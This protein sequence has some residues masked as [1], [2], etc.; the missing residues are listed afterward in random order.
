V[1]TITLSHGLV[2]VKHDKSAT[3]VRG[4]AMTAGTAVTHVEDA[5]AGGTTHADGVRRLSGFGYGFGGA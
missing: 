3:E 1:K 4:L 2:V 5:V